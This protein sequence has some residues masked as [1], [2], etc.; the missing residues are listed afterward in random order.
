M[1]YRRI[2][3]VLGLALL[4]VTA[5]C[6]GGAQAS[7]ADESANRTID[8]SGSST[9]YASPDEAV[10]VVAI[11]AE[12]DSAGA[13]RDQLAAAADDLT[14]SLEDAGVPPGNV[15]TARYD[16]NVVRDRD[17]TTTYRGIHSFRVVTG[18]VDGVGDLVDVA[19]AN[20]ANRVDGVQFRLSP[21]ARQ[22]LYQSALR[23]ALT[24]A[25]ENADTLADESGLSITGVEHVSASNGGY[26]YASAGGVTAG[27]EVRPS[28]VAVTAHVSVTYAAE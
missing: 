20:G 9:L 17:G 15:V 22:A 10:L 1:T 26:V 24:T 27:T 12:G 13:V 19:L 25:R 4:L 3:P 18:D 21:D 28:Q 23:E 2:I 14:G 7:G 6:L 11:E 8:V 16:V 5:G